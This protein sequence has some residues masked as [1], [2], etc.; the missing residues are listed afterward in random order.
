M[1][2]SYLKV[3]TQSKKGDSGDTQT[4]PKNLTK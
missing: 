4:W 3:I 2:E 1:L